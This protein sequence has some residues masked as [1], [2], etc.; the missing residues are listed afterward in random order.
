MADFWIVGIAKA[1]EYLGMS[2]MPEYIRA[3]ADKGEIAGYIPYDGA[4]PRFKA[5][6]LD[7][8]MRSKP[9]YKCAAQRATGRRQAMTCGG[10]GKDT[11]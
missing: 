5:S 4:R 9:R 8:W 3:L 7:A 2:H 11:T 1:A 10:H 6:D